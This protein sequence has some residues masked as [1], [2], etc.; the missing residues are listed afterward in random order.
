MQIKAAVPLRE[1]SRAVL[2]T[3]FG[4]PVRGETIRPGA[5][6]TPGVTCS[7]DDTRAVRLIRVPEPGGVDYFSAARICSLIVRRTPLT[8]EAVESPP[9]RFPS[10]TASLT[11]SGIDSARTYS[12]S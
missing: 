9:N 12:S 1:R 7:R 3:R 10:S 4:Q 2:V 6:L 5:K 11:T 8:N